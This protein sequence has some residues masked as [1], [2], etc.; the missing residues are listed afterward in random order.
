MTTTASQRQEQD[1]RALLDQAVQLRS[2]N[3]YPEAMRILE[4]VIEAVS[5][6]PRPR[7]ML[8]AMQLEVGNTP[9]GMATLETTI[10]LNPGDPIPWFLLGIAALTLDDLDR[11]GHAAEQALQVDPSFEDARQLG[12]LVEAC[13]GGEAAA[14]LAASLLELAINRSEQS[15][16]VGARVCLEKALALDPNN[17]ELRLNYGNLIAREGLVAEGLRQLQ[18]AAD[19]KP[20]WL[21]PVAQIANIQCARNARFLAALRIVKGF[22]EDNP[23]SVAGWALLSAV[24]AKAGRPVDAEQAALKGLALDPKDSDCQ[25]VYIEALAAL[26]RTAEALE[27]LEAYRAAR[28]DEKLFPGLDIELLRELGRGEEVLARIEGDPR[29]SAQQL[30]ERARLLSEKDQL[31]DETLSELVRLTEDPKVDPQLGSHA[32]F[33]LGRIYARRRD[34][35]RAFKMYRLANSIQHSLRP[36][37][38]AATNRQVAAIQRW[39]R[40]I[41]RQAADAGMHGPRPIFILGLARSGSTLTESILAAHPAVAAG[42]EQRTLPAIH[43]EL[44]E[45]VTAGELKRTYPGCLEELSEEE[46]ASLRDVYARQMAGFR[47]ADEQFVTDKMPGNLL[48]VG[49]ARVLFPDCPV[50][51]CLRNPLDACFSNYI[52][53]FNEGNEFSY[54]LETMAWYYRRH[55]EVMESWKA[56]GGDWFELRFET[57]VDEPEETV[58]AL[59]DHIGLDFDPA[60]LEFH[61]SERTVRTASSYQVRQPINRRG[62]GRWRNY[63]HHLEPLLAALGSLVPAADAEE[64]RRAAP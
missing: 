36:P 61:R 47:A 1:P 59:L 12:E 14:S 17:A 3:R 56:H 38:Y 46:L 57:L 13:R 44:I 60:C 58:R 34:F 20:D 26:G 49:L 25:R 54:D 16:L 62:V 35:D 41:G 9:A 5:H 18:K 37:N 29:Q 24:H 28:P 40:P 4:Q 31:D 42:G 22:L 64:I 33:A 23:E 48:R 15:D 63:A 55:L 52:Q 8:A 51:F 21:L 6:H 50:I 10:R 19:L 30:L 43:H 7:L 39:T 27:K 32:Y 11:A 45:R 2:Q 53:N